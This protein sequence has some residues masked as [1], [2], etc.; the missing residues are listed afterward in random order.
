MKGLTS[1]HDDDGPP[2]QHQA[3]DAERRQDAAAPDRLARAAAQARYSASARPGEHAGS[4]SIE[5]VVMAAS[6]AGFQ[7]APQVGGELDEF[8]RL[9]DASV[10]SSGSSTGTISRTRPGLA[11]SISTRWP[12]I[13][14]LVDA[15]RDEQDG[16]AG[17]LPD[18][19]DLLVEPVAG[20]LV[21][22]AERLVHQQDLR[23]AGQRPRNRHALALPARHLVRPG[24]ARGPSGRPARAVPAA[25]AGPC[26][27]RRRP[28]AAAARR[29][30]ARCARAAAPHPGTRSR[31]RASCAP[32]R[33][34]APSTSTLPR[35]GGSRSA[36][37]RSRVDLPQPDGPSR[38]RNSPCATSRSRLLIAVTS[39]RSVKKRMP[40]SRHVIAGRC[41]LADCG[42]GRQAFM[43]A[44]RP[45]P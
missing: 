37:T 16:H 33:G 9:A 19:A 6:S 44:P 3:A 15:V 29:S 45:W 34:V 11:A 30:A 1:K 20:D 2:Q 23:V 13:G 42:H 43:R 36:T 28:P 12:R 31:C 41:G 21:E 4:R 14:R 40:T 8:R 18:A 25:S 38:V 26:G 24:I 32:P 17:F 5:R 27:R 39:R 10:R 22:R 7:H 35:L